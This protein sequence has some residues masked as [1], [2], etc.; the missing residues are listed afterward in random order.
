MRVQGPRLG[1]QRPHCDKDIKLIEMLQYA[2]SLQLGCVL[3]PIKIKIMNSRVQSGDALEFRV[4]NQFIYKAHT[5]EQ[6]WSES[7]I[8]LVLMMDQFVFN[9]L[10]RAGGL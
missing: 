4:T 10:F 5:R 3:H 9:P 6:R 1:T 7:L 2:D 8:R